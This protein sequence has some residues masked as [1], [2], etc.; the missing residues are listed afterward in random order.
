[1]STSTNKVVKNMAWQFVEKFSNYFA[2]LLVSLLLARM[3]EP[4]VYGMLALVTVITSVLQLFVD[5]GLGVSLIQKKNADALDFSTV[6]YF[7]LAS[8][9][10]IYL[11]LFFAAPFIADFYNFPELTPVVRVVSLSIVMI[12]VK[13]IQSSC[14]A[15][16]MRFRMSFYASLPS[17]IFGGCIGLLL[18]YFDYG[19]WALVANHIASTTLSTIILWIVVKWRPTLQFSFERLRSLFDFGWKMLVSKI[20]NTAYNNLASFIIGKKYSPEDLAYCNRAD[21]FPAIISAN[22]DTSINAVLF[23]AMAEEQ[24]RVERVKQMTRRAICTSSYIMAPLMMGMAFCAT[25]LIRFLLTDKWLPCVPY[26][27]IYCILYMF[28]PIHSANLSAIKALGRSDL[29]LYLEIAKKV[30]GLIALLISMHYGPLAMVSTGLITSVISQ[31]INSWPNKKLLN[32][33]YLQQLKDIIPNILLAVFMGCCIWPLSLL[34]MPDIVTLLCQFVLGVVI[35]IA[36][37]KLFK[38]ESFNYILQMLPFEKLKKF[39]S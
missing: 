23:P 28:L 29:F 35:Y 4:R 15:K 2:S 9:L 5:S 16:T 33:P 34:N 39:L 32:Y 22:V 10:F 11:L 31:I 26:M 13:N 6:F 36:G 12:G 7:N 19:I 38:Y 30:V 21:I 17:T 24:D 18:A 37:S 25:P 20:I 3:L 8:S 27:Q 14:I 1:M